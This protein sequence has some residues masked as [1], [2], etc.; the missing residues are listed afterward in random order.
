MTVLT[1]LHHFKNAFIAHHSRHDF[2]ELSKIA[3]N[4]IFCSTGYEPE[5]ALASAIEEAMKDYN[6][7]T[8]ILV[9]VGNVNSNLLLGAI[10]ARKSTPVVPPSYPDILDDLVD[11]KQAQWLKT[12][13]FFVAVYRDSQYHV[14]EINLGAT[15]G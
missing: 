8:D 2:S 13:S 12:S 5:D 9:P 15:N 3:D 4:L 11:M 10:A 6:P 1:P 14:R 7:R